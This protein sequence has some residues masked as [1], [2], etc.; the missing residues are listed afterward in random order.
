MYHEKK[1]SAECGTATDL[2]WKK[3]FVINMSSFLQKVAVVSDDF[4]VTWS[5]FQILGAAT[6]KAHLYNAGIWLDKALMALA[7][8]CYI[9]LRYVTLCY[10]MLHYVTLCYVMLHYA[11]LCYIMLHYVTLCYVML[12]Y[13]TLCYIMLHYVTLCYV[14]LHYATLCYT[15]LRYV[16]L[17]YIMLPVWVY[18]DLV[19]WLQQVFKFPFTSPGIDTR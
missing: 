12:H 13:A 16:T 7:T 14:M 5:F 18:I 11:T 2:G 15:M 19:H 4:K 17:C 6:E 8:L 3:Q 9:M 10:V 1:S